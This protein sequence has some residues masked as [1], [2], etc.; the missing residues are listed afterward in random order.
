MDHGTYGMF[1]SV[2]G[3]RLTHRGTQVLGYQRSLQVPDLWKMD[4]SRESGVLSSKL[5][6]A[7]ARRVEAADDWNRRLANGEVHANIM[8]RAAWSIRACF[9]SSGIPGESYAVR[10]N[11]LEREWREKSG[12]AEPSLAWALNDTFGWHFW[13]GGLFK[14][15]L[16]PRIAF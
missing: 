4:P 9:P 10:R 6:E 16:P 5:D 14:A 15:G 3:E 2:H 11:A 1:Y 7:W 8:K 12:V 13:A